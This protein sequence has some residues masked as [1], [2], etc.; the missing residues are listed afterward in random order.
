[1]KKK[2]GDRKDGALLRDLDSMHF[3]MPIIY[4]NRCD[5]EAFISEKIDLT[6]INAYLAEK[7]SANPDYKYNLFQVIVTAMLKT[8]TLRPRMNRFIANS[9]M[10]QRHE[11]SA[12]FVIKKDFSDNGE[13]GLAFIHSSLSDNIDTIHEEIRR[14]VTGNRDGGTDA[15]TESMDLFNRMPRF[16]GKAIVNFMRF[17]DRHGWV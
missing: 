11:V 2:F 5:N 17:L 4:P 10:Y 8:L 3:I 16:L 15:S 9:N 13:E 7:N 6:N 14:Q 12:A 1:M